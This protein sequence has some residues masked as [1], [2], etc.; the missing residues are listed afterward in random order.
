MK[1]DLTAE[2][3]TRQDQATARPGSTTSAWRFWRLEPIAGVLVAALL[4]AVLFALLAQVPARHGV[5]I[6][7]YDAAY[8]QGFY[9]PERADQPGERPYLAGSDGSARWTRGSSFLLFPQLGAPAELTLRLRS[10]T[11]AGA[12]VLV[13]LNGAN[14]LG[15]L[16]AGAEWEEHR[17]LV[18]GDW[19]KPT[20]VVIELRSEPAPVSASDPRPV[21]VLVDRTTFATTGVPVLPYPAQVLY[22]ALIGGLLYLLLA[23]QGP[24]TRGQEPRTENQEPRTKNREPRTENREPGAEGSAQSLLGTRRPVIGL[25]MIALGL[26]LLGFTYLLLYRLQPVYPYPLRRLPQVI[27][28]ALA[29]LLALRDGPA[30]LRRA[31]WLVDALALGTVGAWLASVVLR[32]QEHLVLS[33]PGVEK[34]FRVFATRAFDPAEVFRADG[35]YNLGYPLLLWLATPLAQGNPFLAARAISALS[36]AVLLLASWWLARRLAGRGAAWITV[37]ALASSSFV[38]QYA[39]YV[40]SDMA[41]AALCAVTLAALVEVQRAKGK[42]TG[43]ACTLHCILCTIA[44][45]VAG[46]AFLVRHPGILLLPVGWLALGGLPGGDRTSSA[47]IAVARVLGRRNVQLVLV[48]TLGFAL[49]ILPQ[50]VVNMRDTGQPLYSQQAKNVWLAVYGDGDWGRWAET[51]D[52]VGM[53]DVVLQDPARFF[54]AWWANMRA[55]FG[56]GAEDTGEFG[57]ATQLRLLGFPANW[58]AV[59]G[60]LGWL[61][62]YHEGTKARGRDQANENRP[63]VHSGTLV[64]LAWLVLY[65]VAVSV[66]LS[67]PRFFL[68]LAPVYGVAAG[69]AAVRLG[70][71]LLPR[72]DEAR[73]LILLS[74][75]LVLM[76]WGGFGAGANYVL[77][78]QP[79]AVTPGQP[80]EA[81]TAARLVLETLG[82]GERVVVR[83]A[84][85][86]EEGLALTKYSAVAHLVQAEDSDAAP[87]YLLWSDD[88]GPPPDGQVVGSAGRY[89]LLRL[90]S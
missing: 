38:T 23:D 32:M 81:L 54:G 85:A 10:S 48:Y 30:V 69:W 44:G 63:Q 56:T 64:L 16:R 20:D 75:A 13:L 1:G 18:G 79:D 3:N 8:V 78:Q 68:P 45:L 39:L 87:A 14:E 89:T 80:A 62:R 36:G 72:V 47:R 15:R 21:G 4:G 37:V 43:R 77:R 49:A 51:S 5:D 61:F 50:L 26:L 86:D 40:G 76:V 74:F 53:A 46:A 42:V 6:G 34:D 70:A 2:P 19:L 57:R 41:F 73:R 71:L 7:G 35:F 83:L 60:L 9:D 11:P 24:R 12:E 27:V 82:P 31:P 25:W 58:L 52:G 28:L 33:V 55:F 66:G 67:L 29:A 59:G 90:R 65:V 17:L 84:P 88:L 22:G